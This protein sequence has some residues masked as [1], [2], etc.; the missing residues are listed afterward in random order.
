MIGNMCSIYKWHIC[1]FGLRLKDTALMHMGKIQIIPSIK[2]KIIKDKV[3]ISALKEV[4]AKTE[5]RE[6]YD[7]RN[8]NKNF[9]LDKQDPESQYL[10][11]GL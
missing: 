11:I 8:I 6:I 7:Y 10:I 1:F 2:D 9:I 3:F 5:K 4:L